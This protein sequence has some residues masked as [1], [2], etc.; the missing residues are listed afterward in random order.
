VKRGSWLEDAGEAD[1]AR[2]RALFARRA[3]A[4]PAAAAAVP[5]LEAVL[6]AADG[7]ARGEAQ[8]RARNGVGRASAL[9]SAALLA[10]ACFGGVILVSARTAGQRRSPVV[11]GDLDAAAPLQ[12]APAAG[13]SFGGG[14]TCDGVEEANHLACN[15]TVQ[16]SIVLASWDDGTH[17][18]VQTEAPT[19][20]EVSAGGP[21]ACERE[22]QMSY[23]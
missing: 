16:A 1:E 6:A 22:P 21:L 23:R 9:A 14:G 11:T 13:W 2:E 20:G 5:S 19:H 3:R 15:A 12:A 10:A 4:L 8:S 7:P 17:A 18:C